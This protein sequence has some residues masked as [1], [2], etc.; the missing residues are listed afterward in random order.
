MKKLNLI[1]LNTLII[2]ILVL[3][4]CT[5]IGSYIISNPDIYL[6]EA[7]FINADPEKKGFSKHQFCSIKS[8]KCVS[9]LSATS[10][11]PSDFSNGKT[12]FYN[13]H[14]TGNGVENIITHRMTPDTFNRFKGTAVLLHGYGGKKEVMMATAIYFRAIGMD[15]I[16][17]DLFGHGESKEDFVFA[18]QEHLLLEELLTELEG[19]KSKFEPIVVVGHSMGALPATNLLF[20]EK[21]DA[22]ILL[23][24]MMRFDLAASQY[25]PYKAPMLNKIFASHLDNIVEQ[26]MKEANV[27]LPETEL[28]KNVNK[29]SKPILLVNSN[30]DS[31]SPPDYFSAISNE[32][33]IK[34]TLKGRSHSSLMV[35]SEKDA[36]IIEGWLL[37]QPSFVP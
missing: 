25:L 1:K 9:Y 32:N 12:A 11:Q 30:V 2:C 7:E 23:A 18:T 37:Q 31:V 35:F 34:V 16:I 15:V 13:L 24:P 21:V 3:S 22:G 28:L 33:V 19:R 5:N 17:P 14:S 36:D 4:G 26:A 6:S 10:Y 8:D 20:S 29:T 27:T